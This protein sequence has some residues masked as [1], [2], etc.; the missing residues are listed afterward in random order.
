VI[1]AVAAPCADRA[2]GRLWLPFRIFAVA[3]QDT[4]RVSILEN[5]SLTAEATDSALWNRRSLL[6]L[7]GAGLAVGAGALAGCSSGS[8]SSASGAG[9]TSSAPLT[10]SIPSSSG[11]QASGDVPSIRT[12]APTNA[13]PVGA[14][15]KHGPRSGSAVALTFH[16]AG[17]AAILRRM[18]QIFHSEDATVTVLGIGEWL[19]AQPDDAKRILNGGHELGNHTW[20]HRTMPRL[21]PSRTR[22]EIDRAAAQ[23]RKLTRTEGRWFRPSGTP[24][25]TPLIRKAAVAAGYGACLSYDVDPL[26]YTDPGPASIVRNFA[27]GVRSGSIVS[28]HLGHEGTLSAMPDLLAHLHEKKLRAF[29]VSELLGLR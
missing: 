26:D 3:R 14:D 6:T 27:T 7:L 16:G 11:V 15:V 2:V 13:V 4:P 28:L 24:Q 8:T 9:V 5:T 19:A 21:S 1:P 18:L 20:S 22:S 23:L 29:T 25:S 10:T 12:S 17:D